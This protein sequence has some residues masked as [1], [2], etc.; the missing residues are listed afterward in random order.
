MRET[1]NIS[2]S[3]LEPNKGQLEGI[4]TNP[5][6]WKKTEVVSLAKS[7]EETPE[8]FVAR[9]IIVIKH[10][11]KYVILGGNLRYAAC[12]HLGYKEAPCYVLPEDTPT[13]KIKEIVIK[14]NSSFGEWDKELLQSDWGDL[15]LVDWGVT[16]WKMPP[17]KKEAVDDEY[18]ELR[19][20]K[21][22]ELGD[23][24]QCGK[25]RV[26]CGSSTDE[27]QVK[28]L[29]DGE[30]ADL[31][32]TDPPYN[33][34][35]CGHSEARREIIKNDKMGNVEY[36]EFLQN[37]FG[38]ADS[39]MKPGCAAYVWFY[40][41]EFI[42]NITAFET[43]W[44][45][46]ETLI[47][48]K[49]HITLT[50]LDYQRMY[51]PCLYGWKEGKHYF[52]DTRKLQSVIQLLQDKPVDSMTKDELKKVVEDICSEDIQTSAFTFAKPNKSK[53]H[54]T[55]KPIPIFG[56]FIKNSTR[57]GEKVLDIFGGSGTTMIACEQLDRSAYLMELDPKYVDT[58]IDRWEQFTGEKAVKIAHYGD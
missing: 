55:M 34:G 36:Q 40:E 28:F 51:E 16:E 33:M 54:P 50:N 30:V 21:R 29:M 12:K 31:L 39:V 3:L 23:V 19:A 37:A 13:D 45:L 15:P 8:L 26:M 10:N 46:S 17:E 44:K 56:R 57:V 27:K 5:R 38:A 7:L 49:E 14:D 2:I 11:E 1:Q 53:L 6:K 43:Y 22:A 32:L 35:Y 48:H 9:P 58:I 4:P 47:W 42:N 52:V 18:D 41:K 25:H 24:F 20:P